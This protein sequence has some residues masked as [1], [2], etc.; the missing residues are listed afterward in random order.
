MRKC[1]TRAK[2]VLEHCRCEPCRRA[3][4]EYQTARDRRKVYPELYGPLHTTVPADEAREHIIALGRIG[5]GYKQVARA[6][7]VN[8]KTILEVRTGETQRIR[9]WRAEGILAVTACERADGALVDAGP[10]WELLNRLLAAGYTK[11][12]LAMAL[13]AGTPALQ[14][15]RDRVTVRKARSV[16]DLYERMWKCDPRVR[17]LDSVDDGKRERHRLNKQAARARVKEERAV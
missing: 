4:C 11:A 5:V 15:G 10:T 7:G 13:G 6:L 14:V 9:R 16:R 8:P 17:V 2:Y 3:N 12:G 1:G